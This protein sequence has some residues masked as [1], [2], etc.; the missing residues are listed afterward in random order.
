MLI[1][2]GA[3]IGIPTKIGLTELIVAA[4]FGDLEL[5]KL[6]L[7]KK[8]NIDSINVYGESAL[9]RASLRGHKE[10]VKYL[11]NQGADKNIKDKSGKTALDWAVEN[12]FDDVRELLLKK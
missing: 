3:K 5:V 6:I 10:V 12:K 7:S 11:I 2:A 1:N 9:I 4:D 8:N